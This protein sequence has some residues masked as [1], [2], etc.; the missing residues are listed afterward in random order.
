VTTDVPGEYFLFIKLTYAHTVSNLLHRTL[1]QVMQGQHPLR[2]RKKTT[3]LRATATPTTVLQAHRTLTTHTLFYC[4]LHPMNIA[5]EITKIQVYY[6]CKIY[7]I[8]S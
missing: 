2:M 6:Y 1:L 7:F 3:N 8:M 4:I 5:A